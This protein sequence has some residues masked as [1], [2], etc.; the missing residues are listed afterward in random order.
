MNNEMIL[1]N[2]TK[3]VREIVDEEDLQLNVE[4]IIESIGLNSIGFIKLLVF[5]EDEYEIEFDDDDL[6]FE[7]YSTFGN[8]INKINE[9]VN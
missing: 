8:I 6:N 1:E 5:L 7:K 4:T 2:I 3:K 9:K